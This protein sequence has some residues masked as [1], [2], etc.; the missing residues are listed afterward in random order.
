MDSKINV[1]SELGKGS[2]FYFTIPFEISE[3]QVSPATSENDK[4]NSKEYDDIIFK[5]LHFLVVEDNKINQVITKKMLLAKDISCDIAEDGYMAIEKAK[6]EQYAVILMVIHMPG[7]SG[8]K[9]TQEIRKF[10][11]EVPII[12][13]N[14]HFTR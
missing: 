14:S 11:T 6:K 8:L 3:Q 12:R 5:G 2:T 9:T 10:N 13:L 7:I 4:K 1:K